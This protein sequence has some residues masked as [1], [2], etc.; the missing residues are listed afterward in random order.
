MLNIWFENGLFWIKLL[1]GI[2]KNTQ[3]Q[4]TKAGKATM[5]DSVKR[6][7][8]DLKVIYFESNSHHEKK[9]ADKKN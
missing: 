7:T 6:S 1:V 2:R 9:I 8:Y 5:M 4:Q 3:K